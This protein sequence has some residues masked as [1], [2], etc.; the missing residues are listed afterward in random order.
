MPVS[1][2]LSTHWR[3]NVQNSIQQGTKFIWIEHVVIFY[4]LVYA[5][6]CS[7]E[8]SIFSIIFITIK[9]KMFHE[10]QQ[11]APKPKTSQ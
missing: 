6:A 10:S 7:T 9:E 1:H 11:T 8:L 5:S 4:E 2:A 3:L